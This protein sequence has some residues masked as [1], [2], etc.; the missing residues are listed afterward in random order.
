MPR[1]TVSFINWTISCQANYSPLMI[2]FRGF[3]MMI[4]I[5]FPVNCP[6]M[7]ILHA[8]FASE[9]AWMW[10]VR[11]RCT[12]NQ[13]IVHTSETNDD[14]VT[15]WRHGSQRNRCSYC[16]LPLE[17]FE[18]MI[19]Y[20]PSSSYIFYNWGVFYGY[21]IPGTESANEYSSWRHVHSLYTGFFGPSRT[22]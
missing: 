13:I 10:L 5:Y 18:T 16:W 11:L 21:N 1:L 2:I 9:V 22:L 15:M 3:F 19:L 20:T 14:H 12:Y 17:R 7:L 6:C 4:N 8:S